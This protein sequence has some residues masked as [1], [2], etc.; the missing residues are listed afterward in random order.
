MVKIPYA[1]VMNHALTYMHEDSREAQDSFMMY[2]C[3]MNSLTDAAQKQ[4]RVRGNEVEGTQYYP[5]YTNL[6]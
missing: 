4:V 3:L 6:A 5:L 1:D 2:C